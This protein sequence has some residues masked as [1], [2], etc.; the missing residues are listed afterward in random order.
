MEQGI[1]I[2]RGSLIG[3]GT[4]GGWGGAIA[5]PIF[6]EGGLSL[7]NILGRGAEPNSSPA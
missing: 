7:P 4:G 1:S 5:P 6:L 3:V 2:T